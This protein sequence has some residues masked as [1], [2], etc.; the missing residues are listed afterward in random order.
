[1]LKQYVFKI[2]INK[3][4]IYIV[5]TKCPQINI[6]YNILNVLIV[7]FLFY[8]VLFVLEIQQ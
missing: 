2:H 7:L 4:Y 6:I 8:V 1:M 3:H 5:V